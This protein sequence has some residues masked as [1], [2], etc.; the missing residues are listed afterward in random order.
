MFAN[1]PRLMA[2]SEEYA[3]KL[4]ES[5][6]S[7]KSCS[8]C[9][10]SRTERLHQ[11]LGKSFRTFATGVQSKAETCNFTTFSECECG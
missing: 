5:E 1:D 6:S 4:V 11:D 9:Q 10:K 3:A 7:H 2:E 8:L